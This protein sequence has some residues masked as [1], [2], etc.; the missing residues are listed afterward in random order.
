MAESELARKA[1]W[2]DGFNVKP[3]H[4]R[5]T[6]SSRLSTVAKDEAAAADAKDVQATDEMDAAPATDQP[7]KGKALKGQIKQRP[8]QT[9]TDEAQLCMQVSRG[10]VCQFGDQC[11]YN[12]DIQKYL[13]TKPADL[14]DKCFLFDR[15][16]RCPY[17]YGCRFAKA[18]MTNDG[19]LVVREGVMSEYFICIYLFIY[20]VCLQAEISTLKNEQQNYLSQDLWYKLQ[21]RIVRFFYLKKKKSA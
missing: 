13:A 15:L 4:V 19:Q 7:K 8:R 12:H 17:G 1:S 9:F 16:G 5:M 18:H 10:E 3:E 14:G 6:P 20:F 11:K 21:R 2:R